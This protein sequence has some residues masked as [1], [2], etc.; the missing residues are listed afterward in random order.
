MLNYFNPPLTSHKWRTKKFT[1]FATIRLGNVC[2]ALC[3]I[4]VLSLV[5]VNIT[6][7]GKKQYLLST[8]L[9]NSLVKLAEKNDMIKIVQE[10]YQLIDTFVLNWW[11]YPDSSLQ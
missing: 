2:H 6:N 1:N 8:R 3:R 9:V 5:G 10:P 4:Q 11:V 7:F